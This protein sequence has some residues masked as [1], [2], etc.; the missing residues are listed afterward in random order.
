MDPLIHALVPRGFHCIR[1]E[2]FQPASDDSMTPTAITQRWL[3]DLTEGYRELAARYQGCRTYGLGYSL[4]ALATIRFLQMTTSATFDGMVLLAPPVSLTARAAFV[5]Y[6][7]PLAKV[8]IALPSLAP[9]AVR[10][11][12]G[13][14]LVEY[15]GM[16]HLINAVALVGGTDNLRG[17]DTRVFLDRR[18]ELVSCAGV[19][20]WIEEHHLTSWATELIQARSGAI[21]GYKHLMISEQSL[22]QEAWL[23]LTE[24]IIEHFSGPCAPT[25]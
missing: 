23:T 2:L 1:V 5:R 25:A 15:S 10:A 11:R 7:A 22:G 8:G 3:R 12:P 20:A 24:R 19:T 6:L 21:A 17:I 14:P 13:T 4:G 9:S 18:D 16:L